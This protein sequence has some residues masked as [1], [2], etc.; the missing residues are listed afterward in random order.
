MRM[1]LNRTSKSFAL[2]A[3]CLL[4]TQY[5]PAQSPTAP[6]QSAQQVAAKVDEYM[7]AAVRVSR[8]TGSVLV[9]RDGQLIISKGYGMANYELGVP[10]T[11]QTVFRLAS[12]TKSFTALAVMMLQERGKLSVG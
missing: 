4:T 5:A 7:S 1:K 6:T 11:P 10:N 8:F 2:V 3:F 9:A 12:L